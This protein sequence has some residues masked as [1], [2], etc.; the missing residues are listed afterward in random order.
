MFFTLISAAMVAAAE[1]RVLAVL[2]GSEFD[3]FGIVAELVERPAGV[4]DEQFAQQL[5]EA[6]GLRSWKGEQV[7]SAP[8]MDGIGTKAV[9]S[10]DG[11]EIIVKYVS[12][13]VQ[14]TGRVCRLILRRRPSRGWDGDFQ[15][16]TG[17]ALN[18]FFDQ[19]PCTL[20]ALR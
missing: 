11:R 10:A 5:I 19:Q 9:F 14:R 1:P 17:C 2:E 3:R 16:G 20:D 4:T 8:Q 13:D 15:A 18:Y 7:D 6:S 12:D